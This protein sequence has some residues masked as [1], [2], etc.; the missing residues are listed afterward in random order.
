MK[1][2]KFV[3]KEYMK[4]FNVLMRSVK[5]P[6]LSKE[7][8]DKGCWEILILM[9]KWILRHGILPIISVNPIFESQVLIE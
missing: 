8:F 7:T 6:N 5:H 4:S 1:K 3:L 9:Y 2:W